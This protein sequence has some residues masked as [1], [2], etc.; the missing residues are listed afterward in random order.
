MILKIW[1]LKHTDKKYFKKKK[2]KDK[3]PHGIQNKLS[4]RYRISYNKNM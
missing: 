3:L 4:E 2:D 1:F